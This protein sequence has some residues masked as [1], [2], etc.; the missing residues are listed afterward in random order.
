MRT[1]TPLSLNIK[2]SSHRHLSPT[3]LYPMPRRTRQHRQGYYDAEVFQQQ[4]SPMA[5]VPAPTTSRSSLPIDACSFW[6]VCPGKSKG[7]HMS[8]IGGGGFDGEWDCRMPCRELEGDKKTDFPV[9]GAND[10]CRR[11]TD[12]LPTLGFIS[13]Y[14]TLM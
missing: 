1:S 6:R 12:Q 9:A 3:N 4:L 7:L 5:S 2:R 8:A 14:D 10:P 13:A 11:G